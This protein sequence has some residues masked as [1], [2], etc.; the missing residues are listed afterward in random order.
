MNVDAMLRSLTAKQFAEWEQY[1]KLEPF[2][3]LRADYRTASIVTMLANVNRA[4]KQEPYSLEDFV[5][6]FGQ[7]PKKPQTWQ[8]KLAI[9]R[10]IA[11]AFSAPAKDM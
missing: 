5:L 9:A 1:A 11:M 3:E 8:E 6:K 2:N 7:E 10:A 4:S